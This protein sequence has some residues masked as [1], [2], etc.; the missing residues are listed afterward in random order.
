MGRLICL[1][2]MPTD[3]KKYLGVFDER[4]PGAI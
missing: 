1:P 3:A 2:D 4:N